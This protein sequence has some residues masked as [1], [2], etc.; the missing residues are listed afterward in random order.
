MRPGCG[1][2]PFRIR[3]GLGQLEPSVDVL[4]IDYYF[5][6]NPRF[7]I[8]RILDELV[9]VEEGTAGSC[10][11]GA[12]GSTES[13]SSRWSDRRRATSLQSTSEPVGVA[14]LGRRA[15]LRA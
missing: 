11:A 8:R 5:D 10:I 2:S 15:R 9:E 3:R 6:A 14:E 1:P 7:V 13:V 12:V 4:K